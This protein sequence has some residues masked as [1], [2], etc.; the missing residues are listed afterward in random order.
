MKTARQ[1][2]GN[3][4]KLRQVILLVED[5]PFVR[6]ATCRTLESAGFEVLAVPEAEEA[7]KVYELR[8]GK[9]DLLMTDMTLPGRSG[10]QL[11]RELR[12]SSAQIPVLLTSGYIENDFEQQP[13]EPRTYFLPKPYSRNE[14]VAVMSKIFGATKRRAATQAAG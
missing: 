1:S 13:R 2:G 10:R 5:E 7:I 6:D 3:E 12:I 14:L 8:Q 11:S 9:I 4:R